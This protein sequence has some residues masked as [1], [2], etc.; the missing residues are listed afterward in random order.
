MK[1]DSKEGCLVI[2]KFTLYAQ[3]THQRMLTQ[4][5][6]VVAKILAAFQKERKT[7]FR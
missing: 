4:K 5:V 1:V 6:K 2:L 7:N 3:I